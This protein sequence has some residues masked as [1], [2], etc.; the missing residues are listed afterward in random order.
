MIYLSPAFSVGDIVYR[1]DA[2]TDS[3]TRCMVIS[4]EARIGQRGSQ[5]DVSY[6]V[7]SFNAKQ[8]NTWSAA[9]DELKDRPHYAFPDLPP[10]AVE[11]APIAEM[12]PA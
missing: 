12:V 8:P 11:P 5:W 1:H 7:S 4:I 2:E 9:G 10:A 6:T 3:L